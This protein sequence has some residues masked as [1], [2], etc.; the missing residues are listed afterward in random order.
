MTVIMAALL[1]LLG[2][3]GIYMYRSESRANRKSLAK[4]SRR[5][6]SLG[7]SVRQ[8]QE[9]EAARLPTTA[10][11]G[12]DNINAQLNRTGWQLQSALQ[13]FRDLRRAHQFE[14]NQR[15]L[16]FE[17]L[18]KDIEAAAHFVEGAQTTGRSVRSGESADPMA[19]W[20][21]GVRKAAAYYDFPG[22]SVPGNADPVE[23]SR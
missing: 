21:V 5:V 11:V 23:A 19:N 6:A 4:L 9:A 12:V 3:I 1:L 2:L 16:Q 20:P 17:L 14:T 22:A 8:L 7:I 13:Q 10:V 15:E 18:E